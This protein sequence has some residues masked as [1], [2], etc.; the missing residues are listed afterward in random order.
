MDLKFLFDQG[1]Y[2]LSF[3]MLVEGILQFTARLWLY[4]RMTL[5]WG[6]IGF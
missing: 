5:G 6:L 2:D 3:V 4:D 1:L